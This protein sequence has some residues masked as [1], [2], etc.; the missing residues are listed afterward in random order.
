MN[1]ANFTEPIIVSPQ[2]ITDSTSST[3]INQHTFNSAESSN[4]LSQPSATAHTQKP[5]RKKE[6]SK[7]LAVL[8]YN[9]GKVGIDLSD[10]ICSYATTLRKGVKWYRKLGY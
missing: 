9:N 6:K 5:S 3:A 8:A 4:G 1:S 7:P 2:P 10:Q